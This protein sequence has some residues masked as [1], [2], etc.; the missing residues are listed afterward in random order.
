MRFTTSKYISILFS[1]YTMIVV[2]FFWIVINILF[3]RQWYEGEMMKITRSIQQ[4]MS[5]ENRQTWRNPQEPAN[6]FADT[7]TIRLE[8]NEN[9][10][11]ELKYSS[12]IS[13]IAKLENQYI[14]YVNRENKI[15]YVLPITRLV[16]A[17]LSMIKL[18]LALII[19]FSWISYLFSIFLV[20]KSLRN[21]NNLVEFVKTM[22]ID[23]LDRK[24]PIDW[25]KDDEINTIAYAIQSSADALWQ[26]TSSLKSFVSYASHE[27]KTP[28]MSLNSAIDA[29]E[30]TWNY[31]KAFWKIK[32]W[33]SRMSWLI[34]TLVDTTLAEQK[35]LVRKKIDIIKIID[36]HIFEQKENFL[37]KNIQVNISAPKKYIVLWD[38]NWANIVFKNLIQNSFKY[39]PNDSNIEIK[40]EKNIFYISNIWN[41]EKYNE[42]MRKRFWKQWENY[43]WYGI[44]LYLVKLMCQKMWWQIDSK[45]DEQKATFRIKF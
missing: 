26:Q 44:W 10:I 4:D 21:L 45:Q 6:R 16:E 8:Y 24:V 17:Q 3:F 25:P 37:A 43:E 36:F 40:L 5:K 23:N 30:K 13:N 28:L 20:K 35:I 7:S 18:F 34:N 33:V 22:N 11:K 41:I 27:L 29:G 19:V 31:Q 2:L 1:L 12:L 14:L 42:D 32:D 15:V 39:A 9:L 38:E